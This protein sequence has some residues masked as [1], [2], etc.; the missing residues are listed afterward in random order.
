MA[1]GPQGQWRPADPIASAVHVAKLATAKIQETHAAPRR[2]NP[3]ADGWRTTVA[4]KARA[5][6]LT[7]ER[8]R[9]IA[10]SGAASRWR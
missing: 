8:R 1:R 4:G 9:Q 6:S 7:P 2:S 5:A 3:V 10:A